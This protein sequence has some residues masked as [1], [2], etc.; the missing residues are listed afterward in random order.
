MYVNKPQLDTVCVCARVCCSLHVTA[1]QLSCRDARRAYRPV[2]NQAEKLQQEHLSLLSL[3]PL[4]RIT[5]GD[6]SAK[7]IAQIFTSS[8]ALHPPPIFLLYSAR[9]HEN[10]AARCETAF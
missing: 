3:L 6:W 8:F 4:T 10:F 5:R 2:T 1:G 9:A 7:N